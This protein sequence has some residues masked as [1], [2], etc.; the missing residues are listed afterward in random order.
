MKKIIIVALIV[1]CLLPTFVLAQSLGENLKGVAVNSGFSDQTD[2]NT[3][4]DTVSNL[5]RIFFSLLGVIFLAII[6]YAGFRWMTAGGNEEQIG[7]AKKL[8]KNSI[9][10]L[11]IILASYSITWFITAALTYSMNR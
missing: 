3:V 8:I 2:R 4:V 5:L 6:V 7:E 10:G 11:A 9:I 1:I